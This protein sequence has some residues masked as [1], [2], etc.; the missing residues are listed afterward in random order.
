MHYTVYL[1]M[2]FKKIYFYLGRILRLLPLLTN[3]LEL[4]EVLR[5]VLEPVRLE[6][7]S[8]QF[9]G[10]SMLRFVLKVGQCEDAVIGS[11]KACSEH[12][13]LL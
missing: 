8:E 4:G 13:Q 6:H 11:S 1:R 7:K 9:G 5:I 2:C 12:A 3:L 10:L